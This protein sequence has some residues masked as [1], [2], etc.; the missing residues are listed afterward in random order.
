MFTGSDGA[1]LLT[2]LNVAPAKLAIAAILSAWSHA[3]RNDI[4]PPFE[5]PIK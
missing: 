5:W 4:K 3:I 2:S 1:H